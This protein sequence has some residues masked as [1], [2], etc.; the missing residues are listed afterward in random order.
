MTN[1]SKLN[2]QQEDA[3]LQKRA[4]GLIRLVASSP[5]KRT[6]ALA[7]LHIGPTRIVIDTKHNFL[8]TVV[9]SPRVFSRQKVA[10]RLH[11]NPRFSIL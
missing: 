9:L 4:T 6:W 8:H 10:H 5:L 2:I 1:C 7:S 11:A 3:R